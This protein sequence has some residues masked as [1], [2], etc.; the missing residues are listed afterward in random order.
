M[1]TGPLAYEGLDH[2]FLETFPEFADNYAREFDYWV[3]RDNP[4]G[5]YLILSILVFPNIVSLLDTGQ[6]QELIWRLFEFFEAMASSSDRNVIDLLGIE[7]IHRLLNDQIRLQKAWPY[8]GTK[9][10][11]LAKFAAKALGL[12]IEWNWGPN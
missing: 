8:M 1:T 7:V 12:T 6:N 5:M 3:D 4:P 10:R 11:E 9:T 2:V